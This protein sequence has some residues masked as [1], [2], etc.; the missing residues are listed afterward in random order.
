MIRM[1]LSDELRENV[2][3]DY[4]DYHMYISRGRL[5]QYPNYSAVSHWHDDIELIL[6]LS[7]RMLFNVNGE[8]TT[9]EEGEGILVN[10]KQFHYGFADNYADCDFICILFHPLLICITKMFERE[11]VKPLLGSGISHFHL[12]PRMPWQK[13]ILECIREIYF[14]K[15]EQTTPLFAQSMLCSLWNELLKN[16]DLGE[17]SRK[18]A[19]SKLS[20]LKDMVSFIHE[21]YS[22]KITLADIAAAGH[23]SKRACGNIFLRYQ[24]KTPIEVLTEYRLRSSIELMKHTD[25]TIL[26]IGLSVGFSGASYYAETF[27]KYFGKSP[28]EYRKMLREEKS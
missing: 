24:H 2:K 20:I 18:E 9:I 3:Y 26:E 21:H 25:M 5:S 6:T 7:G 19:D 22:E 12:S 11:Y 8:I 1:D 16:V 13:K 14:S 28:G 27:R 17:E 15:D 23:V 10:S 4:P